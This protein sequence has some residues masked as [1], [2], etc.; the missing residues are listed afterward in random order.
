MT[1]ATGDTLSDSTNAALGAPASSS[2]AGPRAVV[3]G[4]PRVFLGCAAAVLLHIA[5]DN[6]LQ[7]ADGMS[8]GD[9]LLERSW[10]R[11]WPSPQGCSPTRGCGPV[12]EAIIA[13]GHRRS[14]ASS[15]ASSRPATTCSQSVSPA[16]TSPV[17]SPAAS[18]AGA[19][20]T[21]GARPSGGHGDADR[22][23]T[24]Q[25]RA[26]DG[27]RASL[28]RRRPDGAR[29]AARIRLHHHARHAS[30]GARMRTSAPRH[31]DVIVKT[32]DGLRAGGR[33]VPLEERRRD[34]RLPRPERSTGARADVRAAR[35]R[36]AAARP[37]RRGR[38]RGRRRHARLGRRPGTS[39]RPSSSSRP[40]LTSRRPGSAASASRSVARR[41]SQAAGRD[42]RNWPPWS[43]RVPGGG[44]EQREQYEEE[45]RRCRVLGQRGA[46][47][48]RQGR[49]AL[50]VVLQRAAAADVDGR[51]ASGSP[52]ARRC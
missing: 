12:H 33:Y 4:A 16:T 26:P 49:L 45:H 9:H 37:P 43:P 13:L 52:R 31:E 40:G 23:R 32:S 30:D 1:S 39:W 14:P 34:D 21:G 19:D 50:A 47:A 17:W 36:R 35:L 15:S 41:C 20:R 51:G 24:R 10:S 11:C 8:A 6:F 7:P 38:Q 2:S 44:R 27:A 25:L 42:R 22:R 5:D 28:G 48:G 18:G 29:R 3:T 46:G